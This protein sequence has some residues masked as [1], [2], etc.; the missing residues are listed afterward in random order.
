MF[1][2]LARNASRFKKMIFLSSG[3]VYD[4]RYYRPKMKEDYFDAHVPADELGFSKYIAAK[5]VERSERIVELRLFGVFGK[6]EDYSIR[7]ISNLICKAIF[8][9][10]LTMKQDRKFDY[11]YLDDLMPVLEYFIENDGRHKAYNV[12]PDKAIE[13]S[14]L[15][16]RVRV[17]SGTALPVKAAQPG[18]GL[19]YSG[20]NSRLRQEIKGLKFTGIDEAI[21]KML[22][23]Y[24]TNKNK[25]DKKCLLVDK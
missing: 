23:W 18:Q 14:D 24:R 22:D 20:D 3:A 9:L 13:L 15:A 6:Y 1:F 17:I 2:N 5:Y 25:L 8:D 12:T 11:L 7:F 4:R 21:R 10:P 19:E 16:E